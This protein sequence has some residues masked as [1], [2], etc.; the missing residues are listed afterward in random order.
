[1]DMMARIFAI[2]DWQLYS[3]A[4]KPAQNW[5]EIEVGTPD[6]RY[7]IR[8]LDTYIFGMAPQKDGTYSGYTSTFS[9]LSMEIPPDLPPPKVSPTGTTYGIYSQLA[10]HVP[11]DYEIPAQYRKPQVQDPP[12]CGF[13]F[14]G[15]GTAG[16]PEQA[17]EDLLVAHNALAAEYAAKSIE[18]LEVNGAIR[19]L[20]DQLAALD[21]E[22][23]NNVVNTI[24]QE[25]GSAIG[26]GASLVKNIRGFILNIMLEKLPT[27]MHLLDAA[28]D[29]SPGAGAA[30]DVAE[31]V[32]ATQA[33]IA[34]P[35]LA[36]L[37][38]TATSSLAL[39]SFNTAYDL[40]ERAVLAREQ[41]DA[42]LERQELLRDKLAEISRQAEALRVCA[43]AAATNAPAASFGLASV[44]NAATGQPADALMVHHFAADQSSFS[45]GSGYAVVGGS[46]STN[47]L[48][49]SSASA[50]TGSI[51]IAEGAYFVGDE[52]T[53]ALVRDVERVLV[54]PAGQA[55]SLV[56]FDTGA[57]ETAGAIYRL[58]EAAFGHTLDA[59]AMKFWLDQADEGASLL[60]I[61]RT[62][63][64]S[65]DFAPHPAAGSMEASPSF[66]PGRHLF[67]YAES[68][69]NVERLRPVMEEGLWIRGI[70]Q[71]GSEILGSPSDDVIRLGHGSYAIDGG[72]GLDTVRYDEFRSEYSVTFSGP[73]GAGIVSGPARQ[74]FLSDIEA[75]R[76]VDGWL[77]FDPGSTT[78][79]VLRLYQATLGRDPDPI[80][81]GFWVGALQ[82]GAT[83]LQEA[84]R[85][86]VG[87][88]E[89]QARY[90]A[91][92][93]GAFV[94]L[95]Y[96]NVLGRDPD[97]EGRAYWKN[98]LD[99][100]ALTQTGAVLGFSES[101]EFIGATA[102]SFGAGV[103]APDPI[104]VDVMRYYEAVLDRLPD[105]DGLRF[106]VSARNDGLTAKEMANG[107]TG[108][109]EFQARYGALFDEAFVGQLYLN[110]L[111]RPSDPEGL[112]YWSNL[113]GTGALS[114]ADVVEG[115]AYSNEMTAKLTPHAADGLVF[116]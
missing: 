51:K 70:A 74:D 1:M 31:D 57:G 21:D 35:W 83:T 102:G 86:F 98:L 77:S 10:G 20:A 18:L 63:T 67:D 60:E 61:A 68:G 65:D 15:S 5:V 40:A 34:V 22:A 33:A 29:S 59:A 19:D 23:S 112:A 100:G 24:A 93:S 82:T 99:G 14:D 78:G 30:R 89:F 101:A 91:P 27:T 17:F 95:L 113:L 58:H 11:D 3:G 90:G 28:R 4:G 114:R 12:D 46:A 38:I 43:E 111:D 81:L 73:I 6:D 96:R 50:L 45:V 13:S 87:S 44:L 105:A 66:S 9:Y 108:S 26:N 54:G 25:L 32:Q 76:F 8:Y 84:A 42:A 94:D 85:G 16:A 107:F 48:V 56:A 41:Y 37:G 104:A 115:F 88:A 110:A 80:G 116:V 53:G 103:W 7:S 49:L 97:A 39:K 52:R 109:G 71:P 47:T 64:W 69:A 2:Y 72:A 79:S 55:H 106:W 92:D 36:I 62:F 75:L